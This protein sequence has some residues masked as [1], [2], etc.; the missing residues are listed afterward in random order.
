[1]LSLSAES[2]GF[3]K[4]EYL[5]MEKANGSPKRLQNPSKKRAQ[6]QKIT[7]LG[8]KGFRVAW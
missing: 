3:S 2:N 8:G 7:Q 6:I 1:M 5:S 4:D